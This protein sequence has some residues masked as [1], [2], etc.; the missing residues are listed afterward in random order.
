VISVDE[1]AMQELTKHLTADVKYPATKQ[2]IVEA[3][4]NMAHVPDDAR[5]VIKDNLPNREYASADDV[6]AA[7]PM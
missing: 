7:L 6:M 5:R 3:C 2:A 4:D 1:V